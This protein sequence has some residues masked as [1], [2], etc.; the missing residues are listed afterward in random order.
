MDPCKPQKSVRN[1][2]Q[3]DA[4]T[5]EDKLI[6]FGGM[7]D[8]EPTSVHNDLWVFN[9]ATRKWI[10]Q[11]LFDASL[12]AQHELIPLPR[13]AHLSAVSAG[14]LFISGGQQSDNS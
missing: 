6:C 13:Y 14:K 8:S 12:E 11:S 1:G 3:T 7:S 5:G 4:Y 10:S 2:S 9:C